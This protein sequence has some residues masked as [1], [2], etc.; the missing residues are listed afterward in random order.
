MYLAAM[1]PDT[2][3]IQ[4]GHPVTACQAQGASLPEFR[5]YQQL[6][7]ADIAWILETTYLRVYVST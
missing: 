5:I 7:E 6:D 4:S 2:C 1:Q 3:H